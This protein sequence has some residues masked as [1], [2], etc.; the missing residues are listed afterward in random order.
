MA[1]AHGWQTTTL[2]SDREELPARICV[3]EFEVGSCLLPKLEGTQK[4]GEKSLIFSL[5][6]KNYDC[7]QIG[8]IA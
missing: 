8:F 6:H 5:K 3:L 4:I 2:K 1:H 7:Y